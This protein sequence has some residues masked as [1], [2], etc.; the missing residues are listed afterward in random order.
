MCAGGL[1]SWS[2]KKKKSVRRA[3]QSIKGRMA[4]REARRVAGQQAYFA[5]RRAAKAA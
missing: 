5:R 4:Y 2:G 3:N 1:G